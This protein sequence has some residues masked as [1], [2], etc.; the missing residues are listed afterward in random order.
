M[1]VSTHRTLRV[2]DVIVYAVAIACVAITLLSILLGER[3]HGIFG[4]APAPVVQE[5]TLTPS[6]TG[7]SALLSQR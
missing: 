7:I 1:A 3:I 6:I 2:R 4:Y 5:G